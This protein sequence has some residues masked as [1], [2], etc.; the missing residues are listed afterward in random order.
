MHSLTARLPRLMMSANSLG[1]ALERLTRTGKGRPT[2]R[3]RDAP[4]RRPF[5]GRRNYSLASFLPVSITLC[6]SERVDGA[7]RR[8]TK[9]RRAAADECLRARDA[10][11]LAV[12]PS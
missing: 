3:L 5:C 4:E 1:S 7:L 11:E 10:N 8:E 2:S 9:Q 6:A 12:V